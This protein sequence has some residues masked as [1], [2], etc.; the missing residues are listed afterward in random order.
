MDTSK[1]HTAT[2]VDYVLLGVLGFIAGYGFELASAKRVALLKPVLAVAVAGLLTYSTVMVGLDS[3]RF[4]LPAWLQAVGGVILPVSVLLLLFS[5]FLELP[6]AATYQGR[7]DSPKL[8]TT[9]TYALVRH[10]TVPWYVLMLGSLLLLTRSELLLVALPV[11]VLLDVVWVVLQ[12]R[13]HLT[14]A[15]PEYATY[16]RT[17]PMLIPNRRSVSAF[18]RSLQSARRQIAQGG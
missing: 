14:R 8:V 6:F 13:L 3:G 1:G 4:W 10:P 16:Q 2:T 12:E 9:G 7:T 15:F 18:V 17:T 5:M 11:W